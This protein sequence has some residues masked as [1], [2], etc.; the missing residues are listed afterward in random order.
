MDYFVYIRIPILCVSLLC[1]L[2]VCIKQPDPAVVF[3]AAGWV[4]AL[5]GSAPLVCHVCGFR[6]EM[7]E[8][9]IRAGTLSCSLRTY[10]PIYVGID[11]LPVVRR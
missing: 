9:L 5:Q 11:Q 6:P 10:L 7:T 3:N 8:G 2:P 1:A 4:D